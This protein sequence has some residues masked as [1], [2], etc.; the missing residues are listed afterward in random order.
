MREGRGAG[1]AWMGDAQAGL[2][3]VKGREGDRLRLRFPFTFLLSARDARHG[4]ISIGSFR[5]TED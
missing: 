3:S 5:S 1:R 4:L 2:T